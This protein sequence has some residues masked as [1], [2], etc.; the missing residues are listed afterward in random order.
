MMFGFGFADKAGV[1]I[2]AFFSRYAFMASSFDGIM[3]LGMLGYV[4]QWV[5]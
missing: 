3:E 4:F 5:M 2:G 1:Q